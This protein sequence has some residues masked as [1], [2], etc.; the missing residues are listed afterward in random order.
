MHDLTQWAVLPVE[1]ASKLIL[2]RLTDK[3]VSILLIIMG[4]SILR[5]N[6]AT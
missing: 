3:R 1:V 6:V 5:T 4:C 2:A